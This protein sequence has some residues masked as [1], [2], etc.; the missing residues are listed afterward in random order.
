MPFDSGR[1]ALDQAA[2][3]SHCTAVILT[4]FPLRPA[5]PAKRETSATI[6][7]KLAAALVAIVLIAYGNAFGLGA[8]LDG[9]HFV[10]LD[11]RTHAATWDNVQKICT[12]DYWWPS[13]QDR[14]YRPVTILSFLVNYSIL[15]NETRTAGYHA[16]N[17]ALHVLNVLLAFA[18]LRRL[19]GRPWPAFSAAAIWAVHPVGVETVTNIAGRADLLAAGALLGALLIY[20]KTEHQSPGRVVLLL[21]LA[22]GA[23]LAKET[24]VVLIPLMLLWDVVTRRKPQA[25]PYGAAA[26]AVA[27][28]ALARMQ[29]L[30]A[31]PWP[32]EGFADNPLRGASFWAARWTA[33][34]MLGADLLLLVWPARLTSDRSFAEAP[35]AGGS[36]PAAWLAL[37]VVVAIGAAVLVRRRKNP[38]LLWAA[39]LFAVTLLPASNLIFVI[40]A[41]MA[42]RFLYLPAIG[43]AVAVAALVYRFAPP[44][45]A[46]GVL[47]GAVALFG[48]R[49]LARNPDWDSNTALMEHDAAVSPRSYRV[50]QTLGEA[51]FWSDPRHRERG[52]AEIEKAWDIL[53]DLPPE[54]N[55][56]QI[57]AEL[58]FY[59]VTANAPEAQQKALPLLLKAAEISEASQRSYD[60]AQRRHGK[61]LVKPRRN[62]QIYL[63]LGNTYRALDRQADA[64]TA[65]R[66]AMAIEPS[67]PDAYDG[68][69]AASSPADA[70]R[71]Q[72]EKV[73]AGGSTPQ[74]L[75]GL[76]TWYGRLPDG[77]CAVAVQNGIAVLNTSCPA[78]QRDLCP[79]SSDLNRLF[80]EA[81]QPERAAQFGC[82]R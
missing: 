33:V 18:L 12:T 6:D 75:A 72:L 52:I 10:S 22:L 49:T 51:L 48:A 80:T 43:F 62:E 77:A 57:P 7:W 11:A 34:R 21:A 82:P 17:I 28:Y 63:L 23:A 54:R 81:R 78:V 69:A 5:T 4:F 13:S 79:A 2:Q 24:G 58:A 16:V 70:A 74:A 37:A 31:M 47:A 20:A 35:I 45:A 8:A 25:L 41:T 3:R 60:E 39:G 27:I 64:V 29:V 30:G 76:G 19:F 67:L 46:M 53:K 71:L 36:D 50:H 59:Y 56:G 68:A 32:L 15:G 61:P 1:D 44:R 55:V 9:V 73:L 65:Y 14:L 26:I 66:R 38:E 40:G 42:E